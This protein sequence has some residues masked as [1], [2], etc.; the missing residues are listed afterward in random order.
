ML[1]L[2]KE[3]FADVKPLFPEYAFVP[4][5]FRFVPYFA[6][7]A[8][9][10]STLALVD[11]LN[12]RYRRYDAILTAFTITCIFNGVHTADSKVPVVGGNK[13]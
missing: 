1:R 9:I 13:V 8:S 2:P 4:P 5:Y 6:D 11:F 10:P 7:M 3:G 12:R